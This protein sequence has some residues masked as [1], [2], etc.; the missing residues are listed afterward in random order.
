MATISLDLASRRYRDNGL[1]VL[2][3]C[4]GS[5]HGSF[6]RLSEALSGAPDPV[7]LAGYL[8]SLCE[9]RDARTLLIDG[10]Q[11]WMAPESA[12]A[13]RRL[14]EKALA[15]PGKTGAPGSVKPKSFT[16]LAE[17]SVALFDA[18]D[19][20][21][22]A[23]LDR[24]DLES[25]RARPVAVESFPAA[26][27]KSLGLA[28]PHEGRKSEP[29]TVRRR[30]RALGERFPLHLEGTADADPTHDELDALV[31]GLGGLA[32]DRGDRAYFDVAGSPPQQIEGGWR[33]GFI[34]SLRLPDAGVRIRRLG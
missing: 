17:F 9:E 26:G 18:L 6:P 15:T 21:G 33:E 11:A 5:V 12:L 1:C 27:W 8:L 14:C 4:R 25:T 29:E 20:R 10:P 32:F 30:L 23:R 19:A 34:L 22:W 3:V 13:D 31:S 28:G 2:E 16:R 7:D 24:I